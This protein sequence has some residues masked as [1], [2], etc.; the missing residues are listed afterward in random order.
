[1]F[2]FKVCQLCPFAGANMMELNKHMKSQHV[3]C[4]LCPFVG[5]APP[6]VAA[7]ISSVHKKCPDCSFIG[8]DEEVCLLFIS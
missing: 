1:M 2:T 5:K 4:S 6:D 8:K 7:H 3:S